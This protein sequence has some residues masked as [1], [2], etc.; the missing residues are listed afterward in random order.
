M[1]P[2]LGMLFTM[3]FNFAPRGFALCAGQ[4]I[5]IQSNTALFSLLGTY[6]GGNGT[7]NFAL[8]DL[9]GRGAVG[10]GQSLGGSYY[11]L[12]EKI[13][14]ES[15][16][17]LQTNMPMHTHLMNALTSPGDQPTPAGFILAEG[18][19]TG[20]GPGSKSTNLYI[21]AAPNTNLSPLTIGAAG[22][23][24][25]I[26]IMQPFLTVNICIATSGLFPAR[27]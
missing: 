24:I 26:G 4:L 9:Q 13:G 1:D 15:A 11:E 16:S 10:Q 6:Y 17:I 14:T 5:A 19:K 8:P 20:T 2:Y 7:S 22:S 21:T 18:P 27:N 23:S 3:G 12:G 25:P